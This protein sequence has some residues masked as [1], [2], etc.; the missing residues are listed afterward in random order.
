MS[1]RSEF[2]FQ[3]KKYPTTPINPP[4]PKAWGNTKT[5]MAIPQAGAQR[6]RTPGQTQEPGHQN[7]KRKPENRRSR[8]MAWSATAQPTVWGHIKTANAIAQAGAQRTRTPG[9]TPEPRHQ[10]QKRTPEYRRSRAT[11]WSATAP[12]SG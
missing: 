8:A 10:Y 5:A 3:G 4:Q 12:P 2:H 1:E 9:Q 6:T 11:A 7:K